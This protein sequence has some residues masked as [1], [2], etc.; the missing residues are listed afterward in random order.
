MAPL[1]LFT[2]ERPGLPGAAVWAWYAARLLVVVACSTMPWARAF[3]SAVMEGVLEQSAMG[4]QRA[5]RPL[6]DEGFAGLDLQHAGQ[7]PKDKECQ[8]NDER[9]DRAGSPVSSGGSSG[10]LCICHWFSFFRAL[11]VGFPHGGLSW[12]ALAAAVR[13]DRV[14]EAVGSRGTTPLPSNEAL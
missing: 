7:H 9:R 8:A 1:P 2:V 10:R 14:L 13:D 5:D 3:L 6:E 12:L 11:V 4:P